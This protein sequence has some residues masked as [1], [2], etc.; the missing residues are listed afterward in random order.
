MA[1]DG[2]AVRRGF[3]AEVIQLLIPHRRPFLMV[4]AVESYTCTGELTLRSY[5]N[6]SAN[7]EVFDGH[8]P[9]WK[10]WPGVYTIEGLGQS[11]MLLAVLSAIRGFCKERGDD[12]EEAMASLENLDRGL[13]LRPGFRAASAQK[14]LVRMAHRKTPVGLASSFDIKLLHPVFAGERLDYF[15]RRTHVMGEVQRFEVEASV[16][17]RPVA[18]GNVGSSSVTLPDLSSMRGSS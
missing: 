11:T 12:P 8:F 7:E 13:R 3:G 9:D 14:L 1:V 6:I 2:G 5:R 4:D 10:V 18:R 16:S 17:G 15:V